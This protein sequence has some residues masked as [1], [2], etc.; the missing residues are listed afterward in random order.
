MYLEF[1]FIVFFYVST[2]R[3]R[4][5]LFE[6]AIPFAGAVLFFLTCSM[7]NNV[8]VLRDSLSFL[9]MLL[10]FT[11]ASL[12]LFLT[13]NPNLED[14]KSY[15]TERVANGKRLSLYEYIVL[16]FSYLIIVESLIHV[17]FFMYVLLFDGWSIISVR[18]EFVLKTFYVF[19]FFHVILATIKAVTEV[20]QTLMRCK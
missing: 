4:D 1:L 19:L 11:M 15:L 13:K 18:C 5:I 7:D 6:V 2:L 9:R 14:S 16:S 10:G 12:A 8:E 20:Y 17:F 3:C